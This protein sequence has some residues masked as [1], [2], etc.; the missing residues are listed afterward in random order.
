MPGLHKTLSFS[1]SESFRPSFGKL[2]RSL[3]SRGVLSKDLANAD[4]STGPTTM[5][6][7]ELSSPLDHGLPVHPQKS[8]LLDRTR[9]TYSRVEAGRNGAT[10]S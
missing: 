8:F 4:A 6:N 10:L 2:C 1:W 7:Y 5:P 3:F 9:D